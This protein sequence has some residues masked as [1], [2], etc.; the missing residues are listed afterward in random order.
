MIA[1]PE[2]ETLFCQALTYACAS[3]SGW[4][5][6]DA[7]SVARC[8]SDLA[9]IVEDTYL[10]RNFRR[11]TPESIS[12]SL[13]VPA[14][15]LP[16]PRPYWGVVQAWQKRIECL[17]LDLR[18]R[19]PASSSPARKLLV[20]ELPALRPM[21]L[22]TCRKGD[23]SPNAGIV[24]CLQLYDEPVLYRAAVSAEA[25][26]E[27]HLRYNV[28]SLSLSRR[29]A[30]VRVSPCNVFVFCRTTHETISSGL[31]SPPSVTLTMEESEFAARCTED[32]HSM[33]PIAYSS[34]KERVYMQSELSK[35]ECLVE[36]LMEDKGNL[37]MTQRERVWI[38][39]AGTVSAL[40]YDASNSVLIQLVGQKRMLLF[41]PQSLL[42]QGIYPLGHPLHRRSRVDLTASRCCA[43]EQLFSNFWQSPAVA[44]GVVEAVLSP[45]DICTF[46]AGYDSVELPQPAVST[47]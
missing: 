34:G 6:L 20:D 10:R 14:D 9:V 41:P 31:F 47:G 16:K 21:N 27:A 11:I 12:F 36:T 15:L 38:S 25:C 32:M 5:N 28:S 18:P 13:S 29:R 46:P 22:R 24:D 44:K 39:T 37:V 30:L 3:A 40:H 1:R 23:S 17:L 43:N 45:G 33:P 2:W 35:E 42:E 7:Q 26:S 4:E 8:A 19:R